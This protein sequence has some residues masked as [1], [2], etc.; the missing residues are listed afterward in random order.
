MSGL[1]ERDRS[2]F[3]GIYVSSDA[4][5]SIYLKDQTVCVWAVSQNLVEERQDFPEERF[6]FSFLPGPLEG[7]K[8]PTDPKHSSCFIY[9]IG[10][11]VIKKCHVPC[12][13]D[14]LPW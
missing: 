2:L 5:K 13:S 7:R 11:V 12:V 14:P 8:I 4:R 10:G 9:L 3:R 6:L 1:G